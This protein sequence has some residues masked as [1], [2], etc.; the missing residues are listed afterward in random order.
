MARRFQN[1]DDY[2]YDD[3]ES[4]EDDVL[5]EDLHRLD[6]LYVLTRGLLHSSNLL[7]VV[8]H[9]AADYAEDVAETAKAPVESSLESYAQYVSSVQWFEEAS[10]VLTEIGT[11]YLDA[12]AAIELS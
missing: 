4:F 8:L 2:N 12:K 5:D 10:A 6:D 3:K 7:T 9:A 1:I 11:D